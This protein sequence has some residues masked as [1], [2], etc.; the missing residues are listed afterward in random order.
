MNDGIDVL[1]DELLAMTTELVSL[2]SEIDSCLG[3]D[4]TSAGA[5]ARQLVSTSYRLD[6]L[7]GD[8]RRLGVQADY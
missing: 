7:A 4:L 5:M 1:V 6:D 8:F 3:W 2:S